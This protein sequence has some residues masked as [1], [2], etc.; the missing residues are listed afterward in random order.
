MR[1]R[2]IRDARLA[3]FF[4]DDFGQHFSTIILLMNGLGIAGKL[5]R[6]PHLLRRCYD[7]LRPGGFVLTDSSDIGYIFE[8]E[9]TGEI[10]REDD[11]SYYGEVDF[12]MVYKD[13]FGHPFD[14]VYVDSERLTSLARAIGFFVEIIQ[15]GENND[16][17]ARLTKPFI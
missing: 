1:F 3:D 7:L 6:L 12:Q 8:D 5:A 16:Y 17:L 10:I 13:C 14:W 2:G 11:C 9:N 15:E 4:K